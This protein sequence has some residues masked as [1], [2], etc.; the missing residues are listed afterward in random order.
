MQLLRKALEGQTYVP[1]DAAALE[2]AAI[3]HPGIDPAPSL[4]ILDRIASELDARVPAASDGREFVRTANQ[5]LFDELGFRGNEANYYDPQ[6]SCLDTVLDRRAGIPI[7]L[8]VVYIEVARRMRRPVQGVGLPGHFIVQFDDGDYSTYIDP[9]HGG[10]LLDVED[11]R[12]R[13]RE[14]AGVELA[15]DDPALA[16]VG[17][18]YILV[19]M[20]NNLRSAYF[21]AREYAKCGPIMDLLI[22]AFPSNAE[23]YK[24]RGIARLQLRHFSGASRDLEM[25]LRNDPSAA[26]RVQITEQLEMIHRWLGRLN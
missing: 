1:L 8:S 21:R 19:R 26:D 22:E 25:Y 7:T 12:R 13:A 15:R 20:L 10:K 5:Y 6:N 17:T 9:F 24:L 18:R 4:I 14:I 16:V 3:E 2:M 11:C 23:Y